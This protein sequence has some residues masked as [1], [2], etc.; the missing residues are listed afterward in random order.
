MSMKYPGN[1]FLLET[2]VT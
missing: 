2:I 1:D